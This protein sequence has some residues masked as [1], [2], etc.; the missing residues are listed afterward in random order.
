M[1]DKIGSA[2]Y[3]FS[4]VSCLCSWCIV[5]LQFCACLQS[6][7]TWFTY[8]IY[9]QLICS[10]LDSVAIEVMA[11][12][13]AKCPVLIYQVLPEYL[14]EIQ[15]SMYIWKEGRKERILLNYPLQIETSVYI[16]ALSPNSSLLFHIFLE[17][18]DSVWILRVAFFVVNLFH[19][20]SFCIFP[21][22]E[23]Y[24]SYKGH[25][26]LLSFSVRLT[27]LSLWSSK[28]D[29]CDNYWHNFSGHFS[30][31]SNSPLYVCTH[32]L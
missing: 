7:A 19:C 17:T 11:E 8:D 14:L 2:F 13:W 28:F 3:S 26:M 10:F 5:I 23:K 25:H 16:L 32:L 15:I 29:P 18:S 1:G 31:L 20:I 12:G 6:T 21:T 27:S 9:L 30:W 24:V 22:R 4:L